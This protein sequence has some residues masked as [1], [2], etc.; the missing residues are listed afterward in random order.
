[1]ASR[2]SKDNGK[3]AKRVSGPRKNPGNGRRRQSHSSLKRRPQS[4]K[5][6]LP[7]EVGAPAE[8]TGEGMTFAA[9]AGHIA[10]EINNPLEYINNYLYLLSE[11][12]PPDFLR[13]DYLQKM[14]TGIANLAALTRDLLDL[15]QAGDPRFKPQEIH[16]IIDGS[17]ESLQHQFHQKNVKVRRNYR[18]DDCVIPCS[19][20]MLQQVFSNVIQN[21]LDA[22]S[23]E[24]GMLS[25]TT[26]CS[27]G[28]C[29]LEFADTGTGI[30]GENLGKVFQPFFTTKKSIDK[31]GTGLG[32]TLCYNFVRCHRGTISLTSSPGKGTTVTIMLPLRVERHAH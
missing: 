26:S 14:E 24:E 25:V 6:S 16:R 2:R 8:L 9:L 18:C 22:M 11:S 3:T 7:V 12:L 17:I 10:H 4:S 19:E 23:G 30:P 1:M 13:R 27:N 32:L 21:A 5:H 15:S 20:Q 28:A 31:R 29:I